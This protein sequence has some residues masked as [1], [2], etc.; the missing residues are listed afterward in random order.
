MPASL[1]DAQQGRHKIQFLDRSLAM[2]EIDIG[3]QRGKVRL[4]PGIELSGHIG[5]L[6]AKDITHDLVGFA[7]GLCHVDALDRAIANPRL[8]ATFYTRIDAWRERGL[9]EV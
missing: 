6:T 8:N 9:L 7:Q 3:I 2:I 5:Q 4:S 1:R